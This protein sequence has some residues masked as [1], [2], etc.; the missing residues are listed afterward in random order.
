METKQ[1]VESEQR[2]ESPVAPEA[3]VSDVGEEAN[4][5]GEVSGVDEAAESV[6][7]RQFNELR[8]EYLDYRANSINWWLRI[9]G[10][11]LT[12]FALLIP[13]VGYLAHQ[14]FESLK[15]QA[16]E[17]VNEAG[18][19]ANEAGK[20]LEKIRTHETTAVEIMLSSK[21]TSV[22][23]SFKLGFIRI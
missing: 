20:Y 18:Q 15:S 14:E 22:L 4:V 13:F 23:S 19:Y 12:I 7:Q 6:I 8:R 3:K 5:S 2:M 10:I 16:E 9:V 11:V 21:L 17:H 1:T